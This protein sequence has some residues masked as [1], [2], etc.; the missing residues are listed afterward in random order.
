[1]AP[2]AP[3]DP[4]HLSPIARCHMRDVKEERIPPEGRQSQDSG[5][6]QNPVNSPP[7]YRARKAEEPITLMKL[8][9]ALVVLR[10]SQS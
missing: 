3:S 6:Q 5:A 4:C 7:R 8:A 1:M 9:V 2:D 10:Q